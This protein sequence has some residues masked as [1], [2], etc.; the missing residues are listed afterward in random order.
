MLVPASSMSYSVDAWQMISLQTLT[1]L[2][3]VQADLPIQRFEDP[4]V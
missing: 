4:V 3:A 2:A 1:E